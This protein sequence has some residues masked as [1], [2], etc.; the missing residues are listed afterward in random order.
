MLIMKLIFLFCESP[1]IRPNRNIA[2]R[3]KRSLEI[4][5]KVYAKTLQSKI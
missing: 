5:G 1:N 3:E 4:R 2:L